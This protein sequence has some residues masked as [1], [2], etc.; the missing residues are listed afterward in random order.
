M[1]LE[2]S[3]LA[4]PLA[5]IHSAPSA[6]PFHLVLALHWGWKRMLPPGQLQAT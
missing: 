2:F 4:R 6:L 1:N 3:A 5:W